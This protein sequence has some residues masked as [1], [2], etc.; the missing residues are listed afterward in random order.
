[1]THRLD[2][3]DLFIHR[4]QEECARRRLNF[5][6]IEPLWVAAFHEELARGRV[7]ARVLL[8]M[9]SEHHQPEEPY[10]RLVRL[11][12]QQN[13]RVID[14]PDTARAACD[15]E[16]LHP[17]L[18]WWG[19]HV[20]YTLFVQA[21]EIGRFR[22]TE[23]HRR[24]LGSSFVIKPALG[25]GRQGV[26]LDAVR[27]EDLLRSYAAWPDGSYLLQQRIIPQRYGQRPAYFRVFYVFGSVWT[28]WWDCETHHYQ[29]ASPADGYDLRPVEEIARRIAALTG[30]QFFSSEIAQTETGQLVAIDYVND[31]CHLLSQGA[32]PQIG[33]PDGLVCSI[34]DRLVEAAQSM[35]RG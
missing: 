7:W 34:A 14:H 31:Q 32:D 23:E 11:A 26:I 18:M 19:I 16:S 28:C 33:V 4:V 6:L 15:K 24:A 2:A 8:N 20:P 21:K 27:E 29:L 22:L 35:L 3:D 1:M 13:T 17:R 9:H 30:M 5:F 12:A 10:H 25:Y